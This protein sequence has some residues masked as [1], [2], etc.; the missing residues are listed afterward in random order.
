MTK[1]KYYKC[2][3]V[4]VTVYIYGN[5]DSSESDTHIGSVVWKQFKPMISVFLLYQIA[6]VDSVPFSGVSLLKFSWHFSWNLNSIQAFHHFYFEVI[7][8]K[9]VPIALVEDRVHGFG[10]LDRL[11]SA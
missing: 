10:I 6:I 7:F 2:Q 4:V 3:P 11:H 8:T 5:F 9:I 1:H